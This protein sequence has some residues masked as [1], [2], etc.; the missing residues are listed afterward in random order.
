[1]RQNP[2]LKNQ[3]F[4][5]HIPAKRIHSLRAP[6][7][8][9]EKIWEFHL[10]NLKKYRNMHAETAQNTRESQ[11]A[12]KSLT[13]KLPPFR[14]AS[15]P[16]GLS[17]CECRRRKQKN[18]R[19]SRITPEK[20]PSMTLKL[21]KAHMKAKTLRN[22]SL[23]DSFFRHASRPKGLIVCESRRREQKNLGFSHISLKIPERALRNT[24]NA[25]ESQD[26]ARSFTK[27]Q[28]LFFA[29][30]DKM[31]PSFTGAKG[32]MRKFETCTH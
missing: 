13:K 27:K 31:N 32:A 26:A 24:Q 30:P 11:N 14:C 1:M 12:A 17:A 15:R 29:Q 5:T 10:I 25:C 2:P 6:K 9:A 7:A 19:L 28:H 16:K 21:R 23:K 18:L 3:T 4:S 8:R 20:Y 22:H